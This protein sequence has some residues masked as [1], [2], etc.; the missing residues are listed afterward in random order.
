MIIK[1]G[2]S[3]KT[4]VHRTI[5]TLYCLGDTVFGFL[6]WSN[7]HSTHL[8]YQFTFVEAFPQQ[9]FLNDTC[10]GS[11]R[12]S[13]LFLHKKHNHIINNWAPHKKSHI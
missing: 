3:Y 13:N 2:K 1:I 10:V 7:T 12:V 4:P 9:L 8:L 5:S 6:T 11:I